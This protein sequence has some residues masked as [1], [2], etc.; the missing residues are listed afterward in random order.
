MRKRTTTAGG[1]GPHSV[2]RHAAAAGTLAL[3]AAL[4]PSAARPEA[5]DRPGA[6][7]IAAWRDDKAA[8]FLML[9]DDSVNSHLTNVVPELKRRGMVGTFYINPGA[10][11][12]KAKQDAWEK[13]VPATGM[14]YGN[15]TLTH[16]GAKDAAQL[17]AE[18]AGCDAAIARAFPALK[19]PR[20]VSFGRPGVKKEQ[21]LVTD[22]ELK[23]ALA[24]HHLVERPDIGGRIAG[25]TQKTGAEIL[26]LADQALESGGVERILFHGVG[27]DWLS[28]P[29]PEFL[30]LLD[31]LVARKDR[32]WVTDPIS[33][34]Q[35]E[36]ERAGAE[37]KV[38]EAGAARIR[39]SLAC[40]A[41]PAL[42][43]LPLTLVTRVPASWT[44]CQVSQGKA[45][46]T[47]TAARGEVRYDARPGT[48]EIVILPAG[49]QE[50]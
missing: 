2:P 24:R 39:V 14:V 42:Y 46:A 41:D 20:L 34:H 23:Q 30:A 3:L 16:S 7:R 31:G 18:L 26:R 22:E 12:Y 27:G 17:E 1:T 5:P 37:A 13:E 44:Q 21:W 4:A 8:V 45:K 40:T 29:M 38:L 36:T 9:F 35:Y 33:A 48:E 6:T 10:G 25:V 28:L 15:H 19:T 32:L 47:V 11:W 50:R 49:R 43:D